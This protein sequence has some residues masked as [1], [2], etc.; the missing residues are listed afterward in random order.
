MISR[1]CAPPHR[2]EAGWEGVADFALN[3]AV[4]NARA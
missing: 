3:W 2:A 1:F 4:K